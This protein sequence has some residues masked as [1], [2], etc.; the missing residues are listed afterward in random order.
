MMY[1]EKQDED[2]KKVRDYLEYRNSPQVKMREE[3]RKGEIK[4]RGYPKL[5]CPPENEIEKMKFLGNLWLKS[6]K[7]NKFLICE[8]F[9]EMYEDSRIKLE[10]AGIDITKKPTSLPRELCDIIRDTRGELK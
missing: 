2:E 5:T 4:R 10:N 3:Y 8:D 6:Y 7:E 9:E 1:V